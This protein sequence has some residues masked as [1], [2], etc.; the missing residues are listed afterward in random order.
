MRKQNH[1]DEKAV[2]Q[3][4]EQAHAPVGAYKPITHERAAELADLI[5]TYDDDETAFALIELLRGIVAAHYS[6]Q[7]GDAEGLAL[8]A[9]HRAYSKTMHFNRA[10]NEFAKRDLASDTEERVINRQG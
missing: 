7:Y 6:G 4:T 5:T 9:S 2:S 8:L 1:K 3:T 10:F